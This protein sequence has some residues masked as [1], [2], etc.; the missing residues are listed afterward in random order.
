[1]RNNILLSIS[2]VGVLLMILAFVVTGGNGMFLLVIG[3]GLLVVA[4]YVLLFDL[5]MPVYQDDDILD[6]Y[7]W[8]DDDE[9]I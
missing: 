9:R 1:M 8:N 3:L 5:F 7:N 2:L 6:D 4:L